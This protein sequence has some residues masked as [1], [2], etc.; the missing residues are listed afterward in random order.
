VFNQDEIDEAVLR[1]A[2]IH[3]NSRSIVRLAN[4]AGQYSCVLPRF[5]AHSFAIPV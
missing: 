4:A 2:V 3:H 5:R 1:Y